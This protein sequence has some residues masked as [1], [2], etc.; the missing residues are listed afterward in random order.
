MNSRSVSAEYQ[1]DAQV[2][3]AVDAATPGS[4]VIAIIL[5]DRLIHG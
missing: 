3:A 2:D 4:K 5:T 1:S